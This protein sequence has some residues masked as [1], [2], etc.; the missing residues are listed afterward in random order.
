MFYN[1]EYCL[2]ELLKWE[3]DKKNTENICEAALVH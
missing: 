3:K 1:V 2:A